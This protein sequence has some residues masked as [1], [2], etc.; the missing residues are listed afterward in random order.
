MQE[1]INKTLTLLQKGIPLIKRP[2]AKLADE[3]RSTEEDL[4]LVIK[5]LKDDEIIREIAPVFESSA[6]GYESTLVA[7]EIDESRIDK[8]VMFINEHPGVSHNYKRESSF[9]L[10]FTLTLPKDVSFEDTV[11]VFAKQD[12]VKRILDLPKERMYKIRVAFKLDKT[13]DETEIKNEKREIIKSDLSE[14]IIRDIVIVLQNG[15]PL[16]SDP[17]NDLAKRL[18]ISEDEFLKRVNNLYDCGTIRRFPAMLRHKKI[19]INANALLVWK[20]SDDKTDKLGNEFAKKDFVTH[21]YKRKT[22]SD[23]MYNLYTMIHAENDEKLMNNMK[24][25]KETASGTQS[26][27]LKSL[28]EY[29]KERVK[30]FSPELEKWNSKHLGK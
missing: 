10:W 19:G 14:E 23:W 15:L 27:V 12:G 8:I 17:F 25:L 30:Y 7:C 11:S 6:L 28:K 29:K 16:R 9:N 18:N 26:L 24:Q 20:V 5:K 2:F 4:I 22:Y 1:F 21:C 13:K 3:L